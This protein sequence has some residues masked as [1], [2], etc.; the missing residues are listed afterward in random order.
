MLRALSVKN[1]VL[2][3]ELCIE[4]D[5]GL[6]VLT[7]ETGAGKSIIIDALSLVVGAR[8]NLS[9]IKNRSRPAVI[10]AEFDIT[11]C[12]DDN[13]KQKLLEKGVD[14]DQLVIKR[15]I[16]YDNKSRVL[17]NNILS[18]LAEL[19]DLSSNL[20]E[21]CGQHDQG[22]LFDENTHI[23]MLDKYAGVQDNRKGLAECFAHYKDENEILKNLLNVKDR[24][25]EEKSYLEYIISELEDLEYETGEEHA[26]ESRRKIVAS[27]ERTRDIVQL[28]KSKLSGENSNE[29]VLTSLY[30]VQKALAKASEYFTEIINPLN[31]AVLILEDIAKHNCYTVN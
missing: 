18:N 20:V 13:F 21:I 19:R 6:T 27:A 10:S 15:I 9:L 22:G 4:F 5:E 23:E 8:A 16:S 3:D 29:N 24:S 28:V 26:L 17:I 7:G 25:V 12:A 1:F 14:G 31:E 11:H 2:I 30:V